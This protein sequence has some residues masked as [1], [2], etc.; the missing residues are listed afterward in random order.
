MGPLLRRALLTLVACA[1][2]LTGIAVSAGRPPDDPDDERMSVPGGTAA[3]LKVAGIPGRVEPARAWLVLARA[4]HGGLPPATAPLSVATIKPYLAD[5]ATRV[6]SAADE[7][8]ALLPRSVWE[9]AVFGRPVEPDQLAF[10][11][12]RDRNAALLYTG[13]FSLDRETLAYFVAHPSLVSAIYQDHSG[14][15]AAFAESLTVRA[16]QVVLP[17]GAAR[18]TEWERLVGAPASEPDRFITELLGRDDGRLAWLFDTLASLDTARRTFAL[19]AGLK[20]LYESFGLEQ[21][22]ADFSARPFTRPPVDLAIVLRSIGVASDGTL[23][24]PGDL[25]LWDTVFHGRSRVATRSEMTAGW[26]LRAFADMP[27]RERRLHLD[28]LLF[29]QRVFG[30]RPA[31]SPAAADFLE[32]A[33]SAYPA[34]SALMLALERL[35]FIYSIDFVM[36][37]NAADGLGSGLDRSRAELRVATF[38]GAL[39]IVVRLHD[40]DAIDGRTARSLVLALIELSRT[41]LAGYSE[42]VARWIEDLLL[43]SLPGARGAGVA[44]ADERLLDGL[45]GVRDGRSLPV[46][47]W[48]DET[49]RVD[50]AAGERSRLRKVRDRQGGN[51]L[52]SLLQ[53]RQMKRRGDPRLASTA[54]S[55]VSRLGLQDAR[56]LF[57]AGAH[58]TAPKGGAKAD[59]RVERAEN[60]QDVLLAELL[61][62]YAY[63]IAIGD[64]DSPMLLTVNP[65]RLHDFDIGGSDTWLL[66]HSTR[67]ASGMVLRGSLLG[68]ERALAVSSLRQATLDAPVDA[69][70]LGQMDLQGIAESVATMNP[71]RLDDRGRDALAGVLRRGRERIAIAARDRNEIDALAEHAGVER[72]RRR[73]MRLAAGSGPAAMMQY[74]SLGEACGIG[75]SDATT[76]DMRVWGVAQ[77]LTD[78]SWEQALPLR[79]SMHELGGRIGVGLVSAQFADLHLRVVE[80]LAELKLPAGLAP[81]VLRAAAW[82]LAMHTQMAD[83]DDWLAVVRTAQ[84]LPADRMADHVSALTADGPLVPVA[85]VKH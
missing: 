13:L 53:L 80:W 84:T 6:D 46:V 40:V 50:I 54:S 58:A 2:A 57:G 8:P 68:L 19:H 15:F 33:L 42:S 49:Y 51:D 11:I 59:A 26:L 79:L 23:A 36:A 74:W 83:L 39:A 43:P 63:A 37:V 38:Q 76:P 69:P 24:P 85:P 65:A 67:V 16:A 3:L 22:S 7:V 5:A 32:Q 41:D 21:T 77:R 60:W 44:D 28:T 48:E 73:L 81:G 30:P 71:F 9:Q 66:A 31:A 1:L 52:A 18:T 47:T 70:S 64:P 17:D 55:L 45:A 10:S 56:S 62:S 20:P 4:L 75:Q 72:W 82:D 27:A 12:L 25:P 61:A 35:G 14:T 29:A 34:H 78:G